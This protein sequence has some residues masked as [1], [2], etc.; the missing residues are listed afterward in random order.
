MPKFK[1]YQKVLVRDTEDG[2]WA[3]DLFSH[4]IDDE[5]VTLGNRLWAYCIPYHGNEDLVGTAKSAWKPKKGELVAVSHEG[6]SWFARG[7]IS[8]EKSEEGTIYRVKNCEG[9]IFE[10][11]FET[12]EYRA[13]LEH[14]FDIGK[15]E[16]I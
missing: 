15:K 8:E 14:H 7:F 9:R 5:F 16:E 11:L 10:E 4:Y 13:P 12:W 2:I 6:S 3:V 1:E